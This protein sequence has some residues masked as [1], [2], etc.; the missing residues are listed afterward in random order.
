MK[1]KYLLSILVLLAL[2]SGCGRKLPPLPPTLPDPIQVVSIRFKG[3]EVVAKAVCNVAHSTV[4]L[5]GKPKGICPVCTDDLEVI[6]KIDVEEPGEVTL[7]DSAPRSNYM[8]YR[9]SAQ[10][11]TSKWIT[12]AQ[13]VVH[14]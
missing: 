12:D 4:Y 9:V 13:I 8:V 5:L 6:Q 2:I 3:D 11:D 10:R 7:K 14:K 1:T